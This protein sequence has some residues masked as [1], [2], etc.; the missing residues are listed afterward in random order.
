MVVSGRHGEAFLGISKAVAKFYENAQQAASA[1]S[2]CVEMLYCM[3]SLRC[4]CIA[5]QEKVMTFP[6]FPS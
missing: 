6:C 1:D 2:L 5:P 3:D 4:G